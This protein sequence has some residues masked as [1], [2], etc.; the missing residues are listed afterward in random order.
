M[1]RYLIKKGPSKYTLSV[2]FFDKVNGQRRPMQ[3]EITGPGYEKSGIQIMV[4]INQIQWE[5]GS[6]DSWYFE[7][8]SEIDVLGNPKPTHTKVK[9]WFRT[10]DRGGQ[11]GIVADIK[12]AHTLLPPL[13]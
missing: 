12:P 9:G 2:C 8:Y 7:G 10:T 5:D 3:F 4:V 1:T 11:M 6:G 13:P